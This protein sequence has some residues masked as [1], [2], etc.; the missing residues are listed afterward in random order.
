MSPRQPVYHGSNSSVVNSELFRDALQGVCSA[1]VH[2]PDNRNVVLGKFSPAMIAA[3]GFPATVATFPVSVAGIVEHR[4]EP[5][6]GG[7]DAGGVITRVQNFQTVRDF[8]DVGGVGDDV[9]EVHLLFGDIPQRT[10]SM[11]RLAPGPCP[12]LVGGGSDYFRPESFAVLQVSYH[13]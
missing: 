1:G 4:S 3:S 8:T 12:A 2:L 13:V 7:V 9:C 5:Q 6:M 11:V 10:V